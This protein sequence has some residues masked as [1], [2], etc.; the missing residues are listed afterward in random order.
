MTIADLAGE[1][2]RLTLQLSEAIEALNAAEAAKRSAVEALSKIGIVKSVPAASSPYDFGNP[3]VAVSAP[4]QVS[5]AFQPQPQPQLQLSPAGVDGLDDYGF[6]N[7]MVVTPMDPTQ[8]AN[9]Q[10]LEF[11]PLADPGQAVGVSPG[12]LGASTLA[13]EVENSDEAVELQRQIAEQ[14]KALGVS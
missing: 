8:P 11:A 5:S 12:H 1:I 13:L 2:Q 14:L 3:A 6:T 7:E 10:S 9:P 4:T